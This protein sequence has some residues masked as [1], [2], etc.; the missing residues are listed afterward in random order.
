MTTF[1]RARTH[2]CV[3]EKRHKEKQIVSHAAEGRG[4]LGAI[5]SPSFP[6]LNRGTAEEEDDDKR[7]TEEL[8][9]SNDDSDDEPGESRGG[10]HR[11][12]SL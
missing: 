4:F 6:K 3:R 7:A 10:A 1:K 8:S 12:G 9:A 5:R 2:C 11:Q